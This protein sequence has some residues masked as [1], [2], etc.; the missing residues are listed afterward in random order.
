MNAKL[1]STFPPPASIPQ[2]DS[3]ADIALPPRQRL[4]YIDALR[5][6]ACLWVLLHHALEFRETHSPLLALLIRF[7]NI[8]WLGVS[9][10]L[11]LSGFCLYYPLVRKF[12]VGSATVALPEFAY[13]RAVR[14][15]PPYYAAIIFSLLIEFYLHQRNGAM[16]AEVAGWKDMSAHLLL[17]HNLSAHTFGSINA[18]FGRWLSNRNCISFFRF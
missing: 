5:G 17:L 3:P 12:G 14:L 9:L 2:R 16:G 1:S 15:L 10:F 4:D 11:V 6:F 18:A 8:G 13:R 7:A